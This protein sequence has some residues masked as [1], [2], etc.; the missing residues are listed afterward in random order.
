[1]TAWDLTMTDGPTSEDEEY[2]PE[3]R[4]VRRGYDP[5]QV[6]QVLDD[7]YSSLNDAAADLEQRAVRERAAEAERRRLEAALAAAERRLVES[8]D[9]VAP[10]ADPIGELG[11]RVSTILSAAEAEARATTRRAQDQAQALHDEAEAASVAQRVEADHYASDVRD[12]AEQQALEL[13]TAARAEAEE[14]QS[15]AITQRKAQEWADAETHQ[16]LTAELE[17]R[18]TNAENEFLASAAAHDLELRSIKAEIEAA[19]AELA[20][21]RSRSA[22]E[23]ERLLADART[24]AATVRAAAD[25]VLEAALRQR[26]RVR[27]QLADVRERLA[28]VLAAD[29]E[30]PAR[31]RFGAEVVGSTL[32]SAPPGAALEDEPGSER[33]VDSPGHRTHDLRENGVR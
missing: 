7:L 13:T 33:P 18:K 26:A 19:A 6:E 11:A 14:L 30:T 25:D 23:M 17:E 24:Q 5:D 9:R 1:M 12:R 21:V 4:T 20:D 27:A 28:R 22:A 2:Y 15:Q 3:F 16:R 29:S 8:G 32:S 10:A 31:R